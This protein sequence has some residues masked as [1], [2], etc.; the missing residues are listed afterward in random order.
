[1]L[2]FSQK[3]VTGV[4]VDEGATVSLDIS[5]APQ[6]IEVDAITV[7]AEREKGSTAFLMDQRASSISMV[8]AVGA[9]AISRSPDSDAADVA[10]R[11]TGVTVS[12]GKFVFVRGLG[13]RYS[14][15]ALNGSPLPSPEPEKE[16]VPLDLFPAGFL[17]SLTT[18]KSYTPDQPADF[19]GG[20]VQIRTKDFPDRFQMRLGV[21]T[22]FNSMSQGQD[23]FLTYSGGSRDYLGMDDGTRAF[24]KEAKAY[25]GGL[26]GIRLPA[27]AGLRAALGPFFFKEFTPYSESTP[28]NR[29]FDLSIGGSRGLFGKEVGFLVAG[30]YS[31][32][33]TIMDR[34][35]EKKYRASSFN[36]EIPPEIRQPNID[37]TFD[38][39]TRTVVLGALANLSIN[40]SPAHKLALRAT[41]NRN[42]D[43]EARR[44]EGRNQEDIGGDIRADRLRFVSRT[45][46]WGQVSGE[47]LLPLE[48]RLDWRLNLSGARREEPGLR[49]TLYLDDG[50]AYYLLN[51]AES[52]RMFWS[53]LKDDEVS[54]QLDWQLPFRFRGGSGSFKAGGAYRER[55]RDFAARRFSWRFLGG[56]ATDADSAIASG[57]IVGNARTLGE[58]SLDEVVEPGDQY[59]AKDKRVAGYA[60]VDL[61]LTPALRT[62]I[63]ARYETYRLDL[64]SRGETLK[65]ADLGDLTPSINLVYSLGDRMKIRGAVSHTLDRPEFRE[66]APFQF[67]EAT[68]LRQVFGNP[69]LETAKILSGDLRWDWFFGL[70]EMLSAGVFYKEIDKPIEQVFLAA[71]SSAYSYTNGRKATLRGVEVDAQVGFGHV[72]STLSSFGL[73]G[74]FSWIDS[75]TQVEARGAFVPT[76]VRRPLEGQAEYVLNVGLTHMPNWRELEAGLYLNRLGR[77]L[78][79]AGGSGIPDIY[80]MPRNAVDATL[81][82]GLPQGMTL[83]LKATNL[84]DQVYRFEMSKNGITMVQ[85]QYWT[86]R[87]FSLGLAWD[88]Y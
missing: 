36:P 29:N 88:L 24:P 35:E 41:F 43:D 37:Y 14:Q 27:D 64:T 54:G 70:G 34:E 17:E 21:G 73:S 48:S 83:K 6:A 39:G 3:T 11:M 74:N 50:D 32:E 40:L 45:L 46:V 66:I 86:G 60:M 5:I 81:R 42:T 58:F 71:A 82:V 80:E 61:P 16:V 13:E 18:Q 76:N 15:T 55:D 72:S 30:N 57:G 12:E 44:Y 52:G 79:A 1:M 38:K 75:E 47:H 4:V 2:G 67:T 10:K 78:F 68:S 77:R 63:G 25:L 69:D 59:Q 31:D 8:D 28:L 53:D 26:K 22:S 51:H 56:W 84:L 19:S 9:S 85:H 23:G 49:E 33:Y 7:S 20:A 65:N 62:I 87:T